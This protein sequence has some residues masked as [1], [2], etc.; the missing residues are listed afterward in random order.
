MKNANVSRKD[1][2]LVLVLET[3]FKGKLNLAQVKFISRLKRK[4][5]TQKKLAF[6]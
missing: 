6:T 3:H 2:N 1:N 4:K 5:L